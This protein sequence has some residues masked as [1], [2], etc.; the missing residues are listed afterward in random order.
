MPRGTHKNSLQNLTHEGRPL[1]YG[2][3]KTG[4][5]VSVTQTG[6]ENAKQLINSMGMSVSEF[7]EELG[8]GRVTVIPTQDLEAI[9]DVIDSALLR[10]AITQ[11]NNEF[12]SADQLLADR[13]LTQADLND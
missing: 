5:R 8:R 4:H 6:W 1:D 7:L 13:G 12:I 11:A 9:E 3:P 2:E 10:H